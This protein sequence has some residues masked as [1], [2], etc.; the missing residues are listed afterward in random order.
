MLVVAYATASVRQVRFPSLR[1]IRDAGPTSPDK[2]V[3]NVGDT[4]SEFRHT[5]RLNLTPSIRKSNLSLYFFLL[6]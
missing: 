5:S 6:K 3:E 1:A 4:R 2:M